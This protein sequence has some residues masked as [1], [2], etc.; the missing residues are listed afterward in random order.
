MVVSADEVPDPAECCLQVGKALFR[1]LRAVFQRPEQRLRVRVVVADTRTAAGRRNAQ[2]IH[3]FQ[4]GHRLHR[5]AVVRVQYQRAEQALLAEH[6][7]LQLAGGQFAAFLFV[8]LPGHGLAAV[9]VLD[10]VQ[11]EILPPHSCRQI[12]VIP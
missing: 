12:G 6:A 10:Q 5:C 4:H 3:L 9:D 8:D 2:V 1:P 7:A 11:V